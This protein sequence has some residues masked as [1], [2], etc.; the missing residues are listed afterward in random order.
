MRAEEKAQCCKLK[1]R[2]EGKGHRQRFF[3]L[4]SQR[5]RMHTAS[6][7][8]SAERTASELLRQRKRRLDVDQKMNRQP[9]TTVTGSADK[10]NRPHCRHSD[11]RQ[12]EACRVS[13]FYNLELVNAF[14]YRVCW[15]DPVRDSKGV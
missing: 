2:L 9:S 15:G 1:A 3:L 12:E 14:A 5:K 11:S 4:C 8:G 13:W 7:L 10:Q 6:S